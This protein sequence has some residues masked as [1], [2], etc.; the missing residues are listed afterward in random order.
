[1]KKQDALG[2]LLKV[3]ERLY[4]AKGA[5]VTVDGVRHYVSKDVL[6][7]MVMG[8][9]EAIDLLER[10][11]DVDVDMEVGAMC[12]CAAEELMPRD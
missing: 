1:M 9:S 12:L 7:G 3:G 2:V 10:D 8:I 5:A 11:W 4:G 6:V